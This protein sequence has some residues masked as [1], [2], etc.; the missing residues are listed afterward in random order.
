[1]A[2]ITEYD[3]F[4]ALGLATSI[5]KGDFTP[6]DL[7]E[8]AQA[9]ADALN[10][11]LNAIVIPFDKPVGRATTGPFAGVPFLLKDLGAELEGTRLTNGCVYFK[12]NVCR[13]TH[14]LVDKLLAAGFQIFGRTNTPEFGFTTTT[15][16]AVFGDTKNPW[17]L[18]KSSGGSSGGAGAAVAAGIVPAAHASDG[19][20]SIRIPAS[21]CGL[22]GMKPTRNRVS[23]S[24]IAGDGWSG[25]A[26]THALTRSV[27]DS[28]AILD[29]IAGRGPGDPYCA[30]PPPRPFADEVGAAPGALKIGVLSKPITGAELHPDVILA[31]SETQKLLSGLGHHLED[32]S[33]DVDPDLYLMMNQTLIQVNLAT[34]MNE[35][36][37]AIG[38]PLDEGDMEPLT[39][40]A[41][42]S[43][44][45]TSATDFAKSLRFSHR[46]TAMVDAALA[47]FDVIL[48]PTMAV[49]PANLG[50]ADLGVMDPV[51][52]LSE[53]RGMIAFTSLFN[54]SGHPAM[55][56]PLHW[57]ADNLP[58]GM[59]F[60]GPYG[61]E[62]LLFRLAGQ[63]ETAQPWF[64]KRPPM[65]T[66]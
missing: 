66:A 8:T 50:A 7:M 33:F 12:N 35:A 34:D 43:G 11:D 28:A 4:D 41:Y 29:V 40:F 18:T 49:P 3:Q 52:F 44:K 2:I 15:R 14:L 58:I 6:Q 46:M 42:E 37:A 25:L 45:T 38:R 63:L 59:Q 16:N 60:V 13:R 36:I 19:G 31:L 64:D 22:F 5:A 30:P 1:M 9:R 48:T 39:R 55:S 51:T 27:R 56:V 61:D 47:R 20:G 26:T 32:L 23:L 57:N 65:V 54:Q 21:S 53:I 10:P 17:D 24:P 62:S